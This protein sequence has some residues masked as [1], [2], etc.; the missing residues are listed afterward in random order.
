ME[1][2]TKADRL[3]AAEARVKVMSSAKRRAILMAYRD[4]GPIAPVE[5]GHVVG[6]PTTAVSYHTRVLL[7]YRFLELVKTEPVRGST[8][9]WYIA[10]ERHVVDR[11]EWEV[12]DPM[13]KESVLLDGIDPL[14]KDFGKAVT[15]GKFGDDGRFHLTRMP[16]RAVDREGY[17]ELLEAHMDLM[18]RVDE[19]AGR[20]AERMAESG[21]RPISAT[22]GQQFFAVDG[23]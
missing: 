14:I 1:T 20:A 23:F 4:K 17:D 19:I 10:T 16:I 21:E 22:S 9:S 7:K 8:K 12:L 13:L 5:V 2:K 18:A 11:A 3:T 15:D 6:E